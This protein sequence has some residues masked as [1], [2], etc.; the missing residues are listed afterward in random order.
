MKL[1][2]VFLFTMAVATTVSTSQTARGMAV[3]LSATAVEAPKPHI[4]LTWD[5]DK[6]AVSYIVG[7]KRLSDARFPSEALATLDSLAVTWTDTTVAIGDYYEYRVIKQ[8]IRRTGYDT[9]NKR[10]IL[11]SHLATGYVAAGIRA[12]VPPRGRTL[13]LVD[14]TMS[15]AIAEEL[16]TLVS[17][18]QFEGW[19]P[20]VLTV[21]RAE[22][23]NAQAVQAVRELI[24]A[25]HQTDPLGA[26]LL[27][28]RVPVPYSGDIAPDGHVPDHQGAWPCDGCYG[29][30][31]GTYTDASVNRNNTQRTAQANVPGDGK[32]D[33]SFFASDVDLA[34]G[35]VDFYDMPEFAASEVELIKQYLHKNHAWRTGKV[36]TRWSGIVDNNFSLPEW[37]ASSGWRMFAPFTRDTGLRDA[38]FFGTLATSPEPYLFAYGTGG[39]SNT[40]A[41]GVGNTNDFATKGA[42][43]VFSFLFGSYFG[44][45]DTRNNFLRASL[46]S[47]PQ[48]L[49]CGWSGRPQWY[50]HRMGMGGSIGDAAR[51]SQNNI[52]VSQTTGLGAFFPHAYVNG[53]NLQLAVS[54]DRMVH[55]A[56]MGDPTLRLVRAQPPTLTN[57]TAT[58]DYPNKVELRWQA[59]SP[60]AD[61]YLVFR[62][63]GANPNFVQMTPEPLSGLT[64]TDSLVYEGSLRYRV[65]PYKV[66]QTVGGSILD[67][68]VPEVVS[69]QTTGIDGS[70]HQAIPD[71][72][73]APNPASNIVA[74][75]ITTSVEQFLHIDVVDMVGSTV[76]SRPIGYVSA[77]TLTQHLSVADLSAGCY[78]VRIRGTQGFANSVVTVVR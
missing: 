51:L 29:D 75:T 61:G 18:L 46:A 64:F 69:I 19:R 77:G 36:P 14:E 26:L 66:V 25:E 58:P 8:A 35:R 55:I 4:I 49:T 53:T 48:I 68:G 65:I 45:W 56:L 10:D 3:L 9:I 50:I 47:A 23:F 67:P 1:C 60:T 59:G 71:V 32:W 20:K 63:R 28:G 52:A 38:D 6:G 27:I 74:I 11:M 43:A 30:V 73:I 21:A 17:D 15:A 16:D 70:W 12:A 13:V 37:F 41:G 34:V 22:T 24:N 31:D 7:R 72:S 57:L 39:G 5:A 76:Y 44:D 62:Q 54:G 33:N 2:F 78:S 40:S 42:N